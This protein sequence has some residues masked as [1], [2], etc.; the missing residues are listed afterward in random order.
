MFDF[1]Y[2]LIGVYLFGTIYGIINLSRYYDQTIG[3]YQSNI[4]AFGIIMFS[5]IIGCFGLI[6]YLLDHT[7]LKN[8]YI[9]VLGLFVIILNFILFKITTKICY[10]RHQNNPLLSI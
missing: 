2:F 5:G 6:Y 1:G 9:L 10:V 4:L 3:I 7:N 8:E